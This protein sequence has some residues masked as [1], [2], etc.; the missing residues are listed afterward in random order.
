MLRPAST[1][2]RDRPD[3]DVIHGARSW[4]IANDGVEAWLTLRG[5]HL[6]PVTFQT[7]RGPVQPYTIMPW[8]AERH[9]GTRPGLLRHPRGDFFCLPF[10]ANATPWKGE[11]HPPHGE[12]AAAN[13]K[14]QSFVRNGPE[15]RLRTVMRIRERP[16][17]VVK[18]VRLVAGHPVV[19]TAHEISGLRGP[20]CFGYHPMLKFPARPSSGI[21]SMS[22]IRFGQVRPVAFENPARGGYSS[23]KTGAWFKSLDK[24]ACTDG[25]A[26]D[27]TMYPAR[28]GFD[29]L[30]M[31]GSA[32]QTTFAW[33]AVAFPS[34][35]YV[36]F[37]LKNPG[38]LPSTVLWFSN[39]GRHYA[40]WSGRNRE[41][42]GLEEVRA[43]FD[44]GLKESATPNPWHDHGVPTTW[45]MK[46]GCSLRVPFISGVVS[47]PQGFAAV[48]KISAV[49]ANRVQ[50]T[51]K[52]GRTVTIPLYL[53]WLDCDGTS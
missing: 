11:Q 49:D 44:L 2:R 20:I 39:G 7:A 33:T 38:L 18:D 26:A 40:P 51:S 24:V 17:E 53:S 42:M 21:V 14:L 37:S 35:G 8:F 45:S 6:A 30:V 47:V 15:T 27:L 28:P 43:Y 3:I 23:L 16:G 12:T 34:E 46:R 29:D 32:V 41:V 50:I 10:G 9:P 13:W 31:V 52:K 22:P 25:A 48:A 4:R 5:G 1:A 19:Y 36:W